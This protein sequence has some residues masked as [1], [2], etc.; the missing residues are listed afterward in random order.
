MPP[1]HPDKS[2][3]DLEL[4]L[5]F[6]CFNAEEFLKILSCILV[7]ERIVF[8]SSNYALLTLIMEV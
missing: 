3:I 1:T 6:L 7:E 4:H 5:V 8:L 2:V